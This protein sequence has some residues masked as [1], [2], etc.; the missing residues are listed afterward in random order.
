VSIKIIVEIIFAPPLP[1]LLAE[2]VINN[3]Q[4]SGIQSTEKSLSEGN[5]GDKWDYSVIP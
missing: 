2:I 3:I 5:R 1:D 4:D